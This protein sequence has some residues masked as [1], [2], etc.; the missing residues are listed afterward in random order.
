M[1]ESAPQL[2]LTFSVFG[3]D[4]RILKLKDIH[5]LNGEMEDF[6]VVRALYFLTKGKTMTL[7]RSFVFLEGSYVV[8]TVLGLP[9]N[10]GVNGSAIMSLHLDGK[11]G[12]NNLIM[13]PKNMNMK[14]SVLPRYV[15]IADGISV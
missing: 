15:I 3:S 2:D 11:V 10:F 9:L 13:G 4:V 7:R 5:L 8:P 12:V 6:N 14:G 1:K